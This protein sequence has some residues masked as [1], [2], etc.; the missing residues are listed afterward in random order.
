MIS[1]KTKLLIFNT[2]VRPVLLYGSETWRVSKETSRK[3]YFFVSRCLRS[4]IGVHLP[5]VIRKEKGAS[6][7]GSGTL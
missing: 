2:N 3:L 7:V 5:E 6:G 4:I 1:R